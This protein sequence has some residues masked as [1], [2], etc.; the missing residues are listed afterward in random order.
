MSSRCAGP[1]LVCELIPSA[2]KV[3]FTASGTEAS[4]MAIRLARAHTGKDKIVRFI[5][6]FHG[7]HDNV[8]AG[9]TSN[10]D[11]S[12][13]P[14]VVQSVTDL[15][16]LMPTDDVSATVKLLEKPRRHRR[17][18]VRTVGRLVGPGAAAAGFRAG[19]P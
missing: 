19:D 15:T 7:W 18:D 3:R 2:E 4:H 10:Y 1:R 17:R 9:A 12:S 16:I 14:G 5:G 8:A 13:V 6:H 11:G